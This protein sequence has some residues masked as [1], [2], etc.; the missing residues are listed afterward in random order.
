MSRATS[1]ALLPEPL[2]PTPRPSRRLAPVTA[3]A[4][5]RRPKLAYAL[6]ALGGAAAIGAAQIGL[7]LA[8]THDSF[9]LADLASQQRELNLQASALDD[10]LAG[11]SSPQLLATKASELGMVVAGSASYLRL[12]D[13]AILGAN[14]GAD[15]RSTV[16]PM[17]SGA[18][19][20]ALLNQKA[21][22]AA[23]EPQPADGA[24]TIV[25][26]NLPPPITDGLPSP[27]T[28]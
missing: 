5:R 8:I 1:A 23:E 27:T 4:P 16:D 26:P 9:A 7:S 3:P 2:A 20:N 12:S 15:W 17:G 25:D 21:L 24:S 19:H 10:E 22:A 28:R 6:I 14:T 11:I 18:V 13:A